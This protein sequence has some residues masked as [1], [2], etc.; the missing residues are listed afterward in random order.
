[1][2]ITDSQAIYIANYLSKGAFDKNYRDLAIPIAE[3]SEIGIARRGKNYNLYIKRAAK[4]VTQGKLRFSR[5]ISIEDLANEVA[6][7]I[8]D[9][10]ALADVELNMKKIPMAELA[11]ENVQEAADDTAKDAGNEEEEYVASESDDDFFETPEIIQDESE[12]KECK[13]E[14]DISPSGNRII[15][16]CEEKYLSPDQSLNL[17]HRNVLHISDIMRKPAAKSDSSLRKNSYI[18]RLESD[19]DMTAH[20]NLVFSNMLGLNRELATEIYIRSLNALLVSYDNDIDAMSEDTGIDKRSIS[21]A[22]YE[23]QLIK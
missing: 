14:Y 15:E 22:F 20:M 10:P 3:D 2:N 8:T 9:S 13:D 17:K 23:M 19:A 18:Y 6:G 7:V 11:A 5:D 21:L 4:I 16:K 12:P 1:M